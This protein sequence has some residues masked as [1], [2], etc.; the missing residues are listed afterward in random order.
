MALPS[1]Q[2]ALS[3]ALPG[4]FSV[5]DIK[6]IVR[7]TVGSVIAGFA[8][9]ELWG[10]NAIIDQVVPSSIALTLLSVS[11]IMMSV[12]AL[13]MLIER[14]PLDDDDAPEWKLQASNSQV[15][16]SVLTLL[17]SAFYAG[18]KTQSSQSIGDA[19][20]EVPGGMFLGAALLKIVEFALCIVL[21]LNR[22]DPLYLGVGPYAL[23]NFS[24]RLAK[25][26]LATKESWISLGFAFALVAVS[27]FTVDCTPTQSLNASN[28]IVYDGGCDEKPLEGFLQ[29]AFITLIVCL[30]ILFLIQGLILSFFGDDERGPLRAHLAFDGLGALVAYSGLSALAMEVGRGFYEHF[31]V[32][33]FLSA[34]F[35]YFAAL[36]FGFFGGVHLEGENMSETKKLREIARSQ[37]VLILVAILLGIFSTASLWSTDILY[38]KLEDKASHKTALS[39]YAVIAVLV[40]ALHTVLVKIVEAVAM[41]E[42]KICGIFSGAAKGGDVEVKTK[43]T[44]STLALA[45]AAAVFFGNADWEV[46]LSLVFIG[47]AAAR[48]IGF[49]HR[50]KPDSGKS[51]GEDFLAFIVDTS[52]EQLNIGDEGVLFGALSLLASAILYSVYLFR[53][54]NPLPSGVS[55]LKVWEFIAWLLLLVHVA[56]TVLGYFSKYHA[57]FLPIV[58]FGASSLI[59][60]ILSAGLADQPLKEGLYQYIV[61]ALLTYVLYDGISKGRY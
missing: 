9:S 38:N 61:P 52:A 8:L 27:A 50:F 6:N 22:S 45:L 32:P 41:P 16:L 21:L 25:K 57:G 26:Q 55:T 13:I 36:L 15:Y 46:S 14:T 7:V 59:I 18:I 10:E 19:L 54:G 39:V 12:F 11:T 35:F 60:I 30:S 43:R 58:R 47:A 17:S 44:E 24:A 5:H 51:N 2:A 49:W 29:F 4:A 28:A 40:L 34:N 3:G 53:D 1:D 48:L 33:Q 56:L 31:Y 42:L 20:A 37:G 23:S